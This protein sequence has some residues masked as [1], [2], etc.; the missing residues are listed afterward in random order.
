MKQHLG[1]WVTT[2]AAVLVIGLIGVPLLAN[3]DDGGE[4]MQTNGNIPPIDTNLPKV[5][6]TA[7]FALG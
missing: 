7:T 4:T 1:Y 6:E 2:A 5:T 3:T